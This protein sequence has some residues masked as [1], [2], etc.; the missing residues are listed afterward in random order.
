[1]N[2]TSDKKQAN[3]TSDKKQANK[4]SKNQ[5]KIRAYL[6]EHGVAKTSDIAMLIGLSMPRT[7]AV[8][9][10]MEDVE[11]LGSNRTRVYQLRSR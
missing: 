9:C 4:T 1:M 8:L 11:A 6:Q 3:K 2:K 10:E 5:E 7:R